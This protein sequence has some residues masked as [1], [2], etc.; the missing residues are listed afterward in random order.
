MGKGGDERVENVTM[1]WYLG[2]SLD[3]TDDD[4]PAVRRIIM[5]ARSVL[6]ILG[7]LI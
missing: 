4:Y 7:T 6:G 2:R 1:L 3:K 5:R